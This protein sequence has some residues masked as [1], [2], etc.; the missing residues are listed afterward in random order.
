MA[1]VLP[2]GNGSSRTI[3]KRKREVLGGDTI[4]IGVG[5]AEKIAVIQD[6]ML[7]ADGSARESAR[8]LSLSTVLAE[9]NKVCAGVEM[10]N[11]EFEKLGKGEEKSR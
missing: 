3:D 7:A 10:F 5:K 2:L 11:L 8:D 4:P 6:H 9:W 1:S